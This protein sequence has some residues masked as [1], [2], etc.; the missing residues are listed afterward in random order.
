MHDNVPALTLRYFDCRGR[1]QSFRF[2]LRARKIAF[3]DARVSMKDGF[4][5]W[6][7]V[8]QDRKL[9]GPFAKLPVLHWGDQL[10]A[11]TGVIHDFLH[12]KLGDAARLDD[13]ANLRHAMLAS[14]CR[15]E[16]STPLAM[17][18]YQDAMYPGVDLKSTMAGTVKRIADNLAIIEAALTGWQWFEPSAKR[19]PMLG[20]CL[21]WE[22]LDWVECIFGARFDWRPLPA[23]RQFH[24]HYEHAPLFRRML[25]E[26]PCQLT[27]RPQEAEALQRIRAAQ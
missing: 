11:E 26:H 9:S 4:A 10:V 18:V 14:S 27:G 24:Q 25:A 23:L 22:M 19:Q 6:P 20:D 13:E 5:T 2:Y 8:R 12:R 21:L 17:L 15:S 3:I 16:L 7:A 1:A